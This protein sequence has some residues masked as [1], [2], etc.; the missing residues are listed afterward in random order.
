MGY[1]DVRGGPDRCSRSLT[2]RV[3]QP[4]PARGFLIAADGGHRVFPV[5]KPGRGALRDG[6]RPAAP[7]RDQRMASGSDR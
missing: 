6:L 3:T 4:N 5:E 2:L 1:R 7:Y